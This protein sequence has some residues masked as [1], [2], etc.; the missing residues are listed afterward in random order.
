MPWVPD[1]EVTNWH[2]FVEGPLH[3]YCVKTDQLN[4]MMPWLETYALTRERA[5]GSQSRRRAR[6]WRWL[7]G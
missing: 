5:T 4:T 2:V 1:H 7:N 3:G 6:V